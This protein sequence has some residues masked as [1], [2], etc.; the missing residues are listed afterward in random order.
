MTA[1]GAG[2]G[3]LAGLRA[4]GLL[5]SDD[6]V[7]EV[8]E[9]H[10]V[11]GEG[12]PRVLHARVGGGMALDVLPARGFDLG[13]AW[14]GGLPL[15][16]RSASSD[17]RSLDVPSG[18]AWA[19]RFLGGLLTTCGPLGFGPPRAG[20]GLH[21]DHHHTP[22]RR[23]RVEP[24][25]GAARA[26]L[27]ADVERAGL[28]GP[29]LRTERR[30]TADLDDDGSPRVVVRDTVVSTG[31]VPCPVA[32][33]Y[34]VNLGAPLVVP[35]TTVEVAADEVVLREPCPQVPDV[36]V[37]PEPCDELV[38]AVA[39][40]R[41]VRDEGGTASA[42]VTSPDGFRVR[43]AWSA[44]TLPRLHQWVLPTRG[45][46][47][48]ALEPATAPL[49]GPDRDGPGA[50]AHAGAP[51]LDPGGRREHTVA[52]TVL[53]LPLLPPAPRGDA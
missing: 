35:G 17:A 40:H 50:G 5:A 52:V 26:V 37:L 8:V 46:W 49:F 22:A 13:D 28:F 14:V 38:E 44:A 12:H 27:E 23:V 20:Q 32:V 9:H 36:G 30:V 24:S 43:V 11:P 7:A 45:R 41:G 16:W 31:S 2:P 39:E 18:T 15:S 51:V 42:V 3:G 4:R 19:D 53:S 29:S 10:G 34:H 47:A 1:P 48:L 33:L 25:R 21:G 6:P